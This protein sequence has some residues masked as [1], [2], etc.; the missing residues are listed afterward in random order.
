MNKELKELFDNN[1]T[2]KRLFEELM[3]RAS[4]ELDSFDFQREKWYEDYC[5]TEEESDDYKEWAIEYLKNKEGWSSKLA[6][7]EISYFLLN[8]G[9]KLKIGGD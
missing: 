3:N 4:F 6:E 7:K 8:Y 9:W 1:P 2:L 5:W